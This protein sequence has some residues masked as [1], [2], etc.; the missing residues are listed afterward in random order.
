MCEVR[1]FV[2]YATGF[3]RSHY[4]YVCCDWIHI[5]AAGE[6]KDAFQSPVPA[7]FE[8]VFKSF[9]SSLNVST[10][11]VNN[12]EMEFTPDEVLKRNKV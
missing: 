4:L 8:D 5:L 2:P 7:A 9:K 1:V 10:Y 3:N 11:V 12:D 6:T